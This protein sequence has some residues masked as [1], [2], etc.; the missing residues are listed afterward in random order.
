MFRNGMGKTA[1]RLVLHDAEEHDLGGWA[2]LPFADR[3]N[4]ILKRELKG[5]AI[6]RKPKKSIGGTE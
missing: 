6:V 2:V 5:Y 1:K 4:D 3:V